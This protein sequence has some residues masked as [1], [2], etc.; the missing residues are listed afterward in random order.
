MLF[1]W[2]TMLHNMFVIRNS[3]KENVQLAVCYI[4][5]RENKYENFRVSL[6]KC[7]IIGNHDIFQIF[8]SIFL[9]FRSGRSMHPP[10][11]ILTYASAPTES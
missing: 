2:Q 10:K 8:E 9:I 6:F 11:F 5:R 7:I 3:G 1:N 4:W